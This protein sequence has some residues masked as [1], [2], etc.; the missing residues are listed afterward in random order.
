MVPRPRA[1]QPPDRGTRSPRGRLP[2]RRRPRRPGSVVHPRRQGHRPR[3]ALLPLLRAVRGSRAAPRAEGVGRQV[4]G[5]VRHGLRGHPRGDPGPSEGAR[6]APR[7]HRAL[8]HQPPRRA[9]LHQRRRQALAAARHGA[10]LGFPQRR[11]AAAV[12]P[13]GGGV[14][15]LRRLL[16]RPARANPRLPRGVGP[17]RQHP[18]RRDLRQRRQ[19]RGR[20]QRH[21]QR[22]GVLQRRPV[23]DRAEPGPHRRARHAGIEQPLLHRAGPGPST[24]RSRTGSAGPGTRAGSPT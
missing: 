19:R 16:R 9:R 2:P 24:R 23:V 18:D 12:R 22:V 6:S 4:P 3:Q 5:H 1:R 7:G 10:A 13:D 14:R 15:G 21:V 17:A 20:P 11:R 8:A